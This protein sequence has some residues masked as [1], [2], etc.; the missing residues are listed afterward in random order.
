M[1]QLYIPS[2]WNQHLHLIQSFSTNRQKTLRSALRLLVSI[3]LLSPPAP[4]SGQDDA[5]HCQGWIAC[6]TLCGKTKTANSTAAHP[7]TSIALYVAH[8]SLK[9]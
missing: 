9:H 7:A 5:L 6:E 4:H 1:T 8:P 3:K 2:R